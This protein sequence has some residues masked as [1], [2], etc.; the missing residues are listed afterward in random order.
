MPKQ[1]RETLKKYFK[2]GAMPSQRQFEDLI[3]SMFVKGEDDY[4][5]GEQEGQHDIVGD[6]QN[7]LLN[8]F[9]NI[10][11][12]KER[13]IWGVELDEE[14]N[15]ML[16]TD[17]EQRTLLSLSSKGRIGIATRNPDYTL[18]VKG[19]VAMRGRV[20]NYKNLWSQGK[21]LANGKW[22]TVLTDLKGAH[23]FEIMAGASD[24]EKEK[25][26]VLHATALCSG[27][28]KPWLFG[29]IRRSHNTVQVAQAHNGCCRYKM[30]LRWKQNAEQETHELQ[31][32]T[33]KK[34]GENVPLK[35]SVSKLW[36]L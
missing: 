13:K 5:F 10:D 11:N 16:F 8:F 30:D 26:S 17:E 36:H 15:N 35:I 23:A 12:L 14:T 31:I 24:L 2:K 19:P 1:N 20:G 33:R 6:T 18:D 28:K 7:R 25:Y 3:D 27:Y 29:L 4:D 34:F 32:R 22:Q 9:A 21:L